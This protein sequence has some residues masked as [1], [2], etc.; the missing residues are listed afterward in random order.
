[1]FKSLS[2]SFWKKV[3][4]FLGLQGV[5]GSLT[6]GGYDISRFTPSSVSCNFADDSTRSLVVGIQSITTG[7]VDSPQ[8]SI[9]LLPNRTLSF[10]DGGVSHIWLP[11]ESCRAFET[12]FGLIYDP[13]TEL[14]LV[15]DTIHDALVSRN[16]SI[17]F[18]LANDL[19]SAENFNITLPYAS[20]DLE[21]TT[22][23]PGIT[24]TTRYFPIRRAVNDS[25]NTLGRTF[26]Q[27]AYLITDY[28]RSN[29]SISPVIFAESYKPDIQ[30]ILP[31]SNSSNTTT[32]LGQP[33]SSNRNKTGL[34]TGPIVGITI[35][36]III[37]LIL[38][39][40]M[41]FGNRKRRKQNRLKRLEGKSRNPRNAVLE[42]AEL[43]HSDI[44]LSRPRMGELQED[45]CPTPELPSTHQQKPELEASERQRGEPQESVNV[46]ELE[47]PLVVR[48]ELP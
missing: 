3:K 35:A 5:D 33:P 11:L 8:T 17:T 18:Q 14:Y 9:N 36:A 39:L 20:F 46:Y 42:K 31:P 4:Q 6:L 21:L 13:T 37:V 10:V 41:Y 40:G 45:R 30:A 34:A 15:N 32:S 23:Y 43:Y 12:A 19:T 28:E 48:N 38:A 7:S 1:M 29:F 44:D 25:Q 26:L 47:V 16:A 24:N 22:N 2:V 27:E